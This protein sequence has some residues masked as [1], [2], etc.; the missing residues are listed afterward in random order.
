MHSLGRLHVYFHGP[1]LGLFYPKKPNMTDSYALFLSFGHN[2][3]VPVLGGVVGRQQSPCHPCPNSTEGLLCASGTTVPAG[4]KGRGTSAQA[5]L[6]ARACLYGRRL[7][8][9]QSPTT[10]QS[11]CSAGQKEGRSHML[12]LNTRMAGSSSINR[13]I[14]CANCLLFKLLAA[15]WTQHEDL[16]WILILLNFMKY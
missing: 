11:S 3:T 2:T 4:A 10:D 6:P 14:R 8:T 15:V 9:R 5:A 12:P 7:G 1:I 16:N 13:S